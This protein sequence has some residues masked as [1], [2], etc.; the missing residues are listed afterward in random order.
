MPKI[1]IVGAGNVLLTLIRNILALEAL[2]DSELCLYDPNAEN[3][4]ITANGARRH[5]SGL[6]TKLDVPAQRGATPTAPSS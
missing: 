3:V 4:A 2:Q 5:R 6:A 1:T